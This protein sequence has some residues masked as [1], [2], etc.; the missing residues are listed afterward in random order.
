MFLMRRRQSVTFK[1]QSSRAR[2][3][4]RVIGALA[5]IFVPVFVAVPIGVMATPESIRLPQAP[6]QEEPGALFSHWTHGQFGCF[7]CHPSIFPQRKMTFTHDEM[8]KGLYCGTCHNSQLA[9]APDDTDCET[10][11]RE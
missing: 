7:A 11:H 5:L 10:C 3:V 6:D 1:T 2:H 9:F 4:R 8:D